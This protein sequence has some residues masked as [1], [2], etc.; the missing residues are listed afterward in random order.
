MTGTLTFAPGLEKALSEYGMISEAARGIH[1]EKLTGFDRAL[2]ALSDYFA[3][4]VS[5]RPAAR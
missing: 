1:S 5:D 2:T 4:E 3:Q